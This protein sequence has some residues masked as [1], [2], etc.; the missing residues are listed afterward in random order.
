[1]VE[2]PPI[3]LPTESQLDR[4]LVRLLRVLG[5]SKVLAGVE[6]CTPFANDESEA[7]GKVPHAP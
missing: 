1:M 5:P 4:A 6:A 7:V 3:P 2:S